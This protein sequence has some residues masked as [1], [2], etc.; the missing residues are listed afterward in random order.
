MSSPFRIWLTAVRPFAYSAS[1][2]PVVLGTVLAFQE[3][4][5]DWLLFVLAL[6]SSVLLHTGTNLV[7]DSFDFLRG[8]DTPASYGSSK[9]IT[10]GIL[11]AR[12]VH[13][14]G[15]LCFCMATA[16][17]LYLVV[18]IG[19]TILILG[20]IGILGG[21]FYT[22]RPFQYKYHAMGDFF[23]FFLMGPLMVWGAYFVQTRLYRF[24]PLIFSLPVGFLVAAILVSN[25]IRD[26]R[27]DRGVGIQTLSTLLGFER[28]K[29]EYLVI[30]AFSVLP[31][32]VFSGLGFPFLLAA[33]LALPTAHKALRRVLSVKEE[34]ADE[35][36][37]IDV[38]S[39]QLHLQVG[40]LMIAG[41]M[42][43]SLL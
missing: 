4:S 18:E 33:F 17:G 28:A 38:V 3:G 5:F 19:I 25:N 40:G 6:V 1:V 7:N 42:V 37:A 43:S 32:L 39:A 2:V 15:I 21:Y 27:H 10:G 16:I 20:I 29:W 11:T 35:L 34:K 31:V 41:L 22:A 24:Y 12:Q 36:A 23:V 30:G 14:A 9:M 26:T 13:R 8:V